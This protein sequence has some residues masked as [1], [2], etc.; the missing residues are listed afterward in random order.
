MLKA[1]LEWRG[2]PSFPLSPDSCFWGN[3]VPPSTFPAIF[4]LFFFLP[5]PYPISF[6]CLL[7]PF[8]YTKNTGFLVVLFTLTSYKTAFGELS[9]DGFKSGLH[10]VF[11]LVFFFCLIC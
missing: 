8:I 9:Q 6:P 5:V 1:D 2:T 11:S 4:P 10:F 7:E 3:G